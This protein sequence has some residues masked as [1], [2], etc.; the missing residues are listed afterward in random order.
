MSFD[1]R[2]G[3]DRD[4]Q[5][6]RSQ[7]VHRDPD[8]SIRMP[9]GGIY[10]R[11]N[12]VRVTE[13]SLSVKADPGRIRITH[14]RAKQ[15]RFESSGRSPMVGMNP[16]EEPF[17]I[18][19][20]YSLF[21]HRSIAWIGNGPVPSS[22]AMRIENDDLRLHRTL[23]DPAKFCIGRGRDFQLLKALR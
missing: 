13:A 5:P 11:E 20:R 3:F 1:A 18:R 23:R 15:P 14:F 22:G 12:I 6:E 7:G 19:D 10:R 9:F 16:A 17:V 4:R 21:D 2:V 8:D